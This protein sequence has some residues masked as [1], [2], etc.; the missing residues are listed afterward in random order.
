MPSASVRVA[1]AVKPGFFDSMR[2]PNRRS[3][4]KISSIGSPLRSRTSTFVCSIPPSL[5]SACRRASSALMP[6][7]RCSSMCSWRW[8]SISAARSRSRR[9]R[10]VLPSSSRSR[11]SHARSCLIKPSATRRSNFQIAASDPSNSFVSQ[12]H[13]RIDAHGPPRR[14]IAGQE[15]NRHQEEGNHRERGGIL[16]TNSK[17]ERGEEPAERQR[18]HQANGCARHSEKQGFAKNE[19]QNRPPLCSDGDTDTDFVPA[20]GHCVGHHRVDSD[21]SQRQGDAGKNR[22]E[23]GSKTRLRDR[24]GEKLLHRANVG[25]GDFLVNSAHARAQLSDETRSVQRRS[26]YQKQPAAEDL[27]MLVCEREIRHRD[28]RSLLYADSSPFDRPNHADDGSPGAVDVKS[29]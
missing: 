14:Q 26:N 18:D 28:L 4:S 23:E 21:A 13:H 16:R 25:K 9:S 17:Q 27:C 29:P 7:W 6:V 22:Q 10:P 24:I 11:N 3:C 2:T 8:L 5:I 20:L 12:C 19:A 1:T 15:R